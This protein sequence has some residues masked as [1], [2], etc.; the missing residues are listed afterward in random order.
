MDQAGTSG[1]PRSSTMRKVGIMGLGPHKHRRFQPSRSSLYRR[2]IINCET[3]TTGKFLDALNLEQDLERESPSSRQKKYY[4][5]LQ[6]VVDNY[7]SHTY[8]LKYLSVIDMTTF[9]EY[10]PTVVTRDSLL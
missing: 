1:M 3:L 5:N 2:L 7:D 6:R 9:S 10:D 8:V 4:Q